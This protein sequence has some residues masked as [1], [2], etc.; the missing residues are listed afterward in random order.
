M[1]ILDIRGVKIVGLEKVQE[2]ALVAGF[3]LRCREHNIVLPK[4]ITFRPMRYLGRAGK[5]KMTLK[6]DEPFDRMIYTIV[7]E[8]VHVSGLLHHRKSFWRRHIAYLHRMNMDAEAY[9]KNCYFKNGVIYWQNYLERKG[10]V[11]R[12]LVE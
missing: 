2:P 10:K 7:H 11:E 12:C 8:L 3:L 6:Y 4:L 1:N 9:F 5:Y